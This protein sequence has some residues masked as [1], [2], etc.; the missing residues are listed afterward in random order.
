MECR[1]CTGKT[2]PQ[3]TTKM[4]CNRNSSLLLESECSFTI[5]ASSTPYTRY[6]YLRLSFLKMQ[7]FRITLV[8]QLYGFRKEWYYK[9]SKYRVTVS[10][11]NFLFSIKSENVTTSIEICEVTSATTQQKGT[12]WLRVFSMKLDRICSMSP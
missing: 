9:G 6:V 4:V 10:F 1:Q 5:Y 7:E 11:S 12:N 8:S 2:F 3:K